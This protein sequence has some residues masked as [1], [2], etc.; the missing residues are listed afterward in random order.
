MGD[1]RLWD[2]QV[3]ALVERYRVVRPDLRGWGESPLP[4][5]PF[6]YVEDVRTLLDHLAIDRAALVGNSLGGRV[7]IDLALG[8]PE[9]VAALGLIAPALTGYIGSEELDAFDEEEDALLD[10]GELDEA[11]ALNLRTW[12]DGLG[13][14]AAPVSPEERGRIEE[15][16]RRSFEIVI[17]AYERT[18]PPG[19]VA[20]SEP[21][22]VMRL[23]EIGVPTLVIACTHDQPDFRR[24]AGLLA[25]GIPNA[26]RTDLATAHLPG[27][28]RPDELNR[29]L[30]DFLAGSGF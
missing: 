17:A 13:R 26:E 15:M 24:I 3:A 28:E 14:D 1:R 20:W 12:L 4:G 9:R 25:E 8:H 30:L 16:Q 19:P 29:L 18:P 2:G 22:A 5:G 10:A 27:V 21:P 7:A 6:S 23:H 11:V